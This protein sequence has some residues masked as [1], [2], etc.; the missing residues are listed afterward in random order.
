MLSF[1]SA[2]VS[3]QQVSKKFGGFSAVAD[4]SFDVEPGSVVGV[5]GRNG[6]GKS[7]LVSMLAGLSAPTAGTVRVLGDDPRR[8]RTRRGLGVVPQ[9]VA[10][11]GNLTGN[12]MAEFVS[13]HF[14]AGSASGKD[15]RKVFRSWGLEDFCSKRIKNLSGGQRRRIA[16]GLAFVGNPSLVVLDEPTTGLDPEARRTMW[17]RIRTAVEEGMTVV[18]TSHYLDEIEYLSDRILLLEKGE[19]IEDQP[20]EDFLSMRRNAAVAFSSSASR[21]RVE[22][23]AGGDAEVT[24]TG[25]S[26]EVRTSDSDGFVKDLVESGLQFEE[27]RV[28]GW[29]LEEVLLERLEQ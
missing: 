25:G 21:A 19:L 28:S 18:I 8:A 22:A 6:A 5:L 13:A 23:L 29:S 1:E 4:V 11:P 26:F 24:T 15:Y 12:E 3:V 27:L 7:T 2:V 9:D 14:P 20:I 10:L 17:N 16:V